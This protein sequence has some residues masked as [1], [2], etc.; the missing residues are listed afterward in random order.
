MFT[1]NNVSITTTSQSS[2]FRFFYTHYI[3]RAFPPIILP[4]DDYHLGII[5]LP[6]RLWLGEYAPCKFRSKDEVTGRASFHFYLHE[7]KTER[8]YILFSFL[9][10]RK[11]WFWEIL[12]ILQASLWDRL[13]QRWTSGLLVTT[14]SCSTHSRR[15]VSLHD[16]LLWTRDIFSPIMLW[17]CAQICTNPRWFS[18]NQ[19]KTIIHSQ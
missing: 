1:E 19:M 13:G 7:T 2:N 11:C 14:S 17:L 12:L 15:N 9:S 4:S 3:Q 18:Q 10:Q 6:Y 16:S 8:N 5:A